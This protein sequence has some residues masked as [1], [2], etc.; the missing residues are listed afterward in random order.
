MAYL[1]GDNYAVFYK[2][3]TTPITESADGITP[4]TLPAAPASPVLLGY[5]PAT[6]ELD[7][8]L[9]NALGFAIGSPN[10]S[11]RKRGASNPKLSFKI[12]ITNIAFLAMANRTLNKL[13]S[14]YIELLIPGVRRLQCRYCKVEQLGFSLSETPTGEAGEIELDVQVE[15]MA[16]VEVT[17][18]STTPADIAALVAALDSPLYWHDVRTVNLTDSAAVMTDFRKNIMSFSGTVKHNLERKSERPYFGDDVPLSNTNYEL[19]EHNIN[20]TGEMRLHG[21]LPAAYKSAVANS[22]TWGD[23]EILI[24]DIEDRSYTLTL[25]S[26]FPQNIVENGTEQSGQLS[27]TVP[28]LALTFESVDNA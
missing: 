19:L 24:A 28:F 5:V 26:L 27:T 11:Y 25:G 2:P 21:L 10:A 4:P 15:V 14:F 18:G 6:P 3:E 20:V 1:P 23:A 16:I 8:G 17:T 13:P 9:N 12:R 22:Q 7:Y